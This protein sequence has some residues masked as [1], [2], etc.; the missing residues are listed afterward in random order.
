MFSFRPSCF[1]PSSCGCSCC[2]C[3]F[4]SSFVLVVLLALVVLPLLS[5]R[6]PLWLVVLV[7][8]VFLCCPSCFGPSFSG[9]SSCGYSTCGSFCVGFSSCPCFVLV[10]RL[11]LAFLFCCRGPFR[12]GSSWGCFVL[13]LI[14]VVSVVVVRTSCF[15][16]QCL[17]FV[18]WPSLFVLSCVC[19][20]LVVVLA[21]LRG[22]RSSPANF[23][24]YVPDR[25]V[26][27]RKLLRRGGPSTKYCRSTKSCP[28][29]FLT[30]R[31]GP[32]KRFV[33]ESY[34]GQLLRRGGGSPKL[35]PTG[36]SL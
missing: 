19:V 17:F 34:F 1:G 18:V 28:R 12:L 6:G 32:E 20:L 22:K 33:P 2:V 24:E 3:C 29:R 5:F 23:P 7:L 11:V 10:F 30:E 4:V 25:A 8:V 13:F 35:F 26:G 15:V 16:L 36:R 21:G 31:W 14:L 9:W 27:T